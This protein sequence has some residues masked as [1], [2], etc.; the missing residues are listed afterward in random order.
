M[1]L[2][3]DFLNLAGEYRVASELFKRR[4]FA[5]IT[6]GNRKGAD[7]YAI[8]PNRKVAVVEVKASNSDRFVTG[9][10][11]KYAEELKEHP[12]FWVLYSLKRDG[13]EEFFVLSHEEMA[14]AQAERNRQGAGADPWAYAKSLEGA[15]RGVD[16]VLAKHVLA[17]ANAWE[18]IEE[19]CF[20]RAG[21]GDR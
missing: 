16:N 13:A 15:S 8:G 12:D 11:Q 17:H 18:K 9:F 2:D 14:R 7:I 3:K 20:P 6:Y 1:A 19:W 5:T 10:Y 4:V 21:R